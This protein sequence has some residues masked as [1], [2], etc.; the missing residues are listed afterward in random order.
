MHC[1][2]H[3]HEPVHGMFDLRHPHLLLAHPVEQAQ[4]TRLMHDSGMGGEVTACNVL[5]ATFQP[6]Y[7]ESGSHDVM[8]R[9]I[10][11]P[12]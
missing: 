9:C 4:L 10:A 8:P 7:V 12:G 3:L 1:P 6:H 5:S 11:R 2:K